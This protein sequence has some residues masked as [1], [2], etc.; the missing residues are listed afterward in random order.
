MTWEGHLVNTLFVEF[1]QNYPPVR[2]GRP[3]TETTKRLTAGFL[4]LKPD[5]KGGWQPNG[6]GILKHWQGKVFASMDGTPK[7]TRRDAITILRDIKPVTSNRTLSALK[8]FGRW[9]VE[10]EYVSVNPF[11][12]IRKLF[13]EEDRTRTL[14]ADEIKA[15][16][17]VVETAKEGEAISYPYGKAAQLIL[18]TGQRPGEVFGATWQEFDFAERQWTIPKSRTKNR[19]ADFV[20]PLSELALRVL[21]CLPVRGHYL[22]T[23]LGANDRPAR[24]ETAKARL[25][26]PVAKQLGRTVEHWTYHDLRRTAYTAIMEDFGYVVAD[27]VTNHAPPKMAQTYGSGANLDRW[28]WEALDA[29]GRRLEKIIASA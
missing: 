21:A 3:A 19:K 26:K 16:W 25:G 12:N 1:M 7:L 24:K 4:G 20:V 11:E 9:A 15:L 23:A 6:N 18:A 22:F 2:A 8:L 28:K 10:N 17:Q 5:G 14:K 13:G 27:M 29:W